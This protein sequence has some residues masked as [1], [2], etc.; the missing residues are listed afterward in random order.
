MGSS[1]NMVSMLKE[2]VEGGEKEGAPI[3]VAM[4]ATMME[5]IGASL[6]GGS[7]LDAATDDLRNPVFK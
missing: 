4:L 3:A 5:M 7:V 2:K 6:M 1:A